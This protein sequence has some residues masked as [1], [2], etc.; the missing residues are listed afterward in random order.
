MRIEKVSISHSVFYRKAFSFQNNYFFSTKFY[1]V[2]QKI[3]KTVDIVEKRLRFLYF[4][5]FRIRILHIIF[6]VGTA[7]KII[8]QKNLVLLEIDFKYMFAQRY[9]YSEVIRVGNWCFIR[10]VTLLV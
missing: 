4:A 2:S 9:Y 10:L 8:P 1:E 7:F 5:Y 6:F 3:L